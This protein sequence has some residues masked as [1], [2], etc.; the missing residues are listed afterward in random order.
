MTKL[1]ELEFEKQVVERWL[2]Y[3]PYSLRRQCLNHLNNE[4]RNIKNGL[5]ADKEICSRCSLKSIL[6]SLRL[7]P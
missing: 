1:E 7:L 3:I 2:N 6:E 4:I 5:T